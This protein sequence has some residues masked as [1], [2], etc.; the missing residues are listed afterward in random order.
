VIAN[1]I[2]SSAVNL[3]RADIFLALAKQVPG[4]T[5]GSLIENPYKTWADVNPDLPAVRIEMLGPPPTSGTRDA[6]V[7][8][9]MDRAVSNNVCVLPGPLQSIRKLF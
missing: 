1:A 4:K 5:D 7:E 2:N 9:A 3:S 8:L 6:F